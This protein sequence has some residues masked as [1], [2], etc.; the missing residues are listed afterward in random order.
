MVNLEGMDLGS[1]TVL[2]RAPS[3]HA[4]DVYRVRQAAS[5]EQTTVRIVHATL[6]PDHPLASPDACA[7]F[8][9]AAN[10][11]AELD[12]PHIL[13]LHDFGERNGLRYLIMPDVPDGSLAGYLAPGSGHAA[14]LLFS[15]TAVI[16]G[17]AAAALQHAHDAG[18]VHST[19]NLHTLLLRQPLP[20]IIPGATDAADEARIGLADF[21]LSRFLPGSSLAAPP[22]P[23]LDC[24]APEQRAGGTA[25]PA[26]DQYALACVLYLLLVGQ[27]L[28]TGRQQGASVPPSRRNPALDPAVDAVL[29]TAL[30][31]DPRE[32]YPRVVDFA[33]A[34]WTALRP[35]AYAQRA[36]AVVSVPNTPR[37]L[38][39]YQ[40]ALVSGPADGLASG[41]QPAESGLEM[42]RGPF[43]SEPG[44]PVVRSASLGAAR[45]EADPYETRITRRR[46]LSTLGML[47]VGV[48]AA[49]GG[50]YYAWR[51]HLFGPA[52][53]PDGATNPGVVTGHDGIGVF[54][55]TASTFSL[56]E[57]WQ[58][59]GSTL[60]VVLGQSGD[61]PVAGDWT[62]SG[63]ESIGVFRPSAGIFQVKGSNSTSAPLAYS[64]SFGEPG[65]LPVAGDWLGQG[66][67]GIGVFRPSKGIFLLK[68]TLDGKP[69]DLTI[70]FGAVGDI[71]VAGDWDGDGVAGIGVYRPSDG[72]FYLVN[73][74]TAN[75]TAKPDFTVGLQTGPGQPFT[76]RWGTDG[77]RSGVGMLV[78]SKGMM[79][80]KQDTS[81]PGLPDMR[82]AFG[83][84][85]DLP[86]GGRWA[87]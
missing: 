73:T 67:A 68:Q 56:V 60:L 22:V 21:G 5:G 66:H 43:P 54:R 17:Q 12:Q 34:L 29:A 7:A 30:A 42:P 20:S 6:A 85:G 11:V 78:P 35:A 65:D 9:R 57:S 75:T 81:K 32:R 8:A 63:V 58:R 70:T 77:K 74:L 31:T 44:G 71:P 40:P 51:H 14:P 80:L 1:C 4:D 23:V 13:P 82:F 28:G 45:F 36:P 48:V 39:T 18:L 50:G 52:T 64:V 26:S 37:A 38:A 53:G 83:Q 25:L 46:A 24:Q 84:P 72:R 41:S 3:R 79:Y 33:T 62:G 15:T 61:L 87:R 19:V 16:G 86:L 76:G 55:P 49:G 59:N 2:H 27:P 47:G 10:M 69:P